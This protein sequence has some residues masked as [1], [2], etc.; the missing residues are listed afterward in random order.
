VQRNLQPVVFP[1]TDNLDIAA[2]QIPCKTVGGDYYDIIEL[3]GHQIGFF[4]GDVSGKGVTG[5]LIMSNMQGRFRQIA[6]ELMSPAKVMENLNTL[7]GE[8]TKSPGKFVTAF[9]GVIDTTTGQ[10]TYANAGHNYPLVRR[11]SG[12]IKTLEASGPLLGPFPGLEYTDAQ[13]NFNA[14]DLLCIYTDGISE[15]GGDDPKLQFGEEGIIRLLRPTETEPTEVIKNSIL[16]ACR[17][18]V[19]GEPFDDDWTL[20]LV[21]LGQPGA[22]ASDV[23]TGDHYNV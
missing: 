13:L 2:I 19:R 15:A 20:V 23:S 3:P 8:A 11:A 1:A 10:L 12:E 9:Y 22:D 21:R 7:V 17:K 16:E 18:H 4:V 6:P 14:G 5:S